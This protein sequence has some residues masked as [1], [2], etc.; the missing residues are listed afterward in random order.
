LFS[1][2]QTVRFEQPQPV[3]KSDI[4]SLPVKF[5]GK[6]YSDSDSTAME[7]TSGH[8]TIS[9]GE[10]I[11]LSANQLDSSAVLRGDTL[12]DL[13]SGYQT[14]AHVAGDS[15]EALMPV[16]TDTLL[17]RGER[18]HLRRYRGHFFCNALAEDGYW[19][20]RVLAPRSVNVIAVEELRAPED[21][22]MLKDITPVQDIRRDSLA[23]PKYL[24]NPN[25]KELREL[26]QRGFTTRAVYR[27]VK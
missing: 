25:R 23:D 5:T 8:I 4:A 1:C 6:F 16:W 12:I 20:V 22:D 17:A 11:R 2:D 26:M 15:L 18:Y 21:I 19:T 14:I 9:K 27:R 3:D 24:V 13:S 7:I 10:Y